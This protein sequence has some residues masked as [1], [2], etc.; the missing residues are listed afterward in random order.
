M[1][2]PFF[3]DSAATIRGANIDMG[4]RT[5]MQ[6]VFG[7][8]CGGLALSGGL[9]MFIAHN[10]AI[11]QMLASSWI[12]FVFM[13]APLGILFYLNA[14][15]RRLSV[16][17]LRA[18]FT[19]FCALMGVSLGLVFFQYT[20]AS[21]AR[22]FFVNSAMFGSMAL[23]GYTTKKDLS[24]MGAFLIMGVFGVIIASI[25]NLFMASPM[26][27]WAT[28]VI[29]VVVFTGLTAWDMQRIKQTYDEAHGEEANHK[30]AVFNALSLY[31]NF[32]N[33]LL[34][35]LRFMGERR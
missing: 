23:W 13:L 24:G 17:A 34:F 4:L 8:M 11:V 27:S 19:V 33:A 1:N 31:L 16:G 20:D 3:R 10:V 21:I 9:A 15:M 7:Y 18:W 14:A 32:I 6:K 26:L 29:G 28:S 5:H 2:D 12:S 25:V 35:L 22:A 30:M